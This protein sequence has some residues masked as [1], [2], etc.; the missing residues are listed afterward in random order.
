M[1]ACNKPEHDEHWASSRR[2]WVGKASMA[3]RHKF[4]LIKSLDWRWFNGLVV[5]LIGGDEGRK[6]VRF[7]NIHNYSR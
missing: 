6:E 1:V 5:G 7:T 4:L 2:E 3:I